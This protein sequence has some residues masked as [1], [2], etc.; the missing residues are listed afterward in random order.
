MM[1]PDEHPSAMPGGSWTTP[2]QRA[3][4]THYFVRSAP[5]KDG[6][7]NWRD[8][9]HEIVSDFLQRRLLLPKPDGEMGIV[10]NHVALAVYMDALSRVPLP[11]ERWV[12]EP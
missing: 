8:V 7:E 3:I 11:V 10:A 9:D 1:T 2:L 5:W 12:I 6:S 4:L